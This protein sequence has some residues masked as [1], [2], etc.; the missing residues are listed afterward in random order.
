MDAAKSFSVLSAT[1]A[2]GVM[3]LHRHLLSAEEDE[4]EA[5]E[6]NV[7]QHHRDPQIQ[8][9]TASLSLMRSREKDK[10]QTSML[11]FWWFFF[12]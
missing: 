3:R 6:F 11:R 1:S 7:T 4:G 12:W 10:D 9:L 2:V 5:E 8:D